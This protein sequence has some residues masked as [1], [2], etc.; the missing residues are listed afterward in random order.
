MGK[1]LELPNPFAR[2]NSN[3]KNITIIKINKDDE[4]GGYG[5]GMRE[6]IK[7][8]NTLKSWEEEML[9]IG[10]NQYEMYKNNQFDIY[11]SKDRM[12]ME[13]K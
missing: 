10:S 8:L 7:L 9:H 4:E 6:T 2:E 11:P 1:F 12:V 3:P 13:V 5:D